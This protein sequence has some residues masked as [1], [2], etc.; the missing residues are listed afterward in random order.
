MSKI[1]RVL[2]DRQL[3]YLE[4]RSLLNSKPLAELLPDREEYEEKGF[5]DFE[6]QDQPSEGRP[7]PTQP[8]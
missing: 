3:N 8:L 2:G 6:T 7:Q 1:R 5:D 4:A